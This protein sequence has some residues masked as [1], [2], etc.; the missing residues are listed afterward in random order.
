MA[1]PNIRLIRRSMILRA[2]EGWWGDDGRRKPQ[3]RRNTSV[4]VA[5]LGVREKSSGGGLG[6]HRPGQGAGGDKKPLVPLLGG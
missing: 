5:R 2:D 3:T 6:G 1:G 4:D